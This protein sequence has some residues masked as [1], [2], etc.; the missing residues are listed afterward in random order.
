[1][2]KALRKLLKD[3]QDNPYGLGS[4]EEGLGGRK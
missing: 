4:G 3:F 1:M 2:S